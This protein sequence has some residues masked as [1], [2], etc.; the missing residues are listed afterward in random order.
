MKP[1]VKP[2]VKPKGKNSITKTESFFSYLKQSSVKKEL[3]IIGGLYFLVYFVLTYLYPYPDGI[4]DS[5]GY[6]LAAFQ[7]KYMGFRPFGYS[8]FLIM[9]HGFS[10][11]MGFIVFVQYFLNALASMFFVFTLKYFF[12]IPNKFISI[13]FDVLAFGSVSVLYLTNTILSDSLFTSLT[14]IWAALG[15]W[16]L[17]TD[18]LLPKV[19]LF[20]FQCICLGF[21]LNVRYTGIFYVIVQFLIII[22][23]FYKEKQLIGLGLAVVTI[24]IGFGFY[25]GQIEKTKNLVGIEA[26]SGFSGWQ[27]ANNAMHV[28]HHVDLQPERISDARTRDFATFVKNNDSLVNI[29][30]GTATAKL[31]WDKNS[32]LKIYNSLNIQTNNVTYLYSYTDLGSNVYNKFG[33]HVMTHYPFAFFRY[34]LWPNIQGTI[35]PK[36]DQVFRTFNTE[37]ISADLRTNWFEMKDTEKPYSRSQIIASLRSFLSVYRLIV[38]V[39]MFVSIVYLAV[40]SI[41]K[42]IVFTLHQH[43][44]FWFLVLFTMGYT[45]FNIFS[46]PFELRYTTPI[47]IMQIA[48]II[49]ALF[50]FL[51]PKEE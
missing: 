43:F 8:R 18:K 34:Y 21:L 32:P 19:F 11:S 4:S 6:V 51:K 35:Y 5:G 10:S 39:L 15:L 50:Y 42:K 23:S 1:N 20:I 26:F 45:A 49:W 7:N 13:A 36:A 31:M 28:I 29:P 16:I 27:V 47:H 37:A 9:L 2:N 24:L 33:N 17:R 12:R 40:F 44:M 30:E 22:F 48:F 14:L 38:W 3:Y 46:S 41:K 25:K